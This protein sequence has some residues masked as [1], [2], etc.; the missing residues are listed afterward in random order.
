MLRGRGRRGALPKPGGAQGSGRRGVRPA[1]GRARRK[2][3]LGLGADRADA[4]LPGGRLPSEARGLPSEAQVGVPTMEGARSDARGEG[5]GE[6][7]RLRHAR[8]SI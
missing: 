3:G 6:R 7:G 4:V 8:V 1:G 2:R 5:E